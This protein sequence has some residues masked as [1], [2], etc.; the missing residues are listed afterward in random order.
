M[1][2]DFN[3]H[4][5]KLKPRSERFVKGRADWLSAVEDAEQFEAQRIRQ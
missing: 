1:V 2:G 5:T 4:E 3:L